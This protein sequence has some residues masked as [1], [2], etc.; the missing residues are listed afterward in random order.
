MRNVLKPRSHQPL[1]RALRRARDLTD[2]EFGRPLNLDEL[3]RES[4]YSKFHFARAYAAI[5]G[6]SPV[7]YLT[8]RRVERAKDL[9]RA[10]N[11]TV[12]EIAALVGYSSLGSFS[13]RFRSLVGQSPAQYRRQQSR[14]G[15]P[16]AIPGC[17]VLMWTLPTPKIRNPEEALS[18]RGR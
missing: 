7:A 13:T 4:N 1:L 3:A 6:E 17:F 14:D 10:A 8:R 11:L 9:L 12:T 5:Y 16:P 2:R 18:G 15:G